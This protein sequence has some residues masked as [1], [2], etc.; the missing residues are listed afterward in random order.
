MEF[1]MRR[2]HNCG[3]LQ[4]SI[5][6]RGTG[7]EWTDDKMVAAGGHLNKMATNNHRLLF[8]PRVGAV[9]GVW[10]GAAAVTGVGVAYW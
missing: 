8:S 2:E 4:C 7:L 6:G 9:A 1:R 3:C 10:G 5:D